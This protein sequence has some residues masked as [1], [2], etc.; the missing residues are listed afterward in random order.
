MILCCTTF[1]FAGFGCAALS[2]EVSP[3][4]GRLAFYGFCA[5]LRSAENALAESV[6]AES[7]NCSTFLTDIIPL[8][9][10][11]SFFTVSY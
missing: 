3:P 6:A 8:S 1:F 4:F 10:N 5:L 2:F 11:R 7:F 9:S